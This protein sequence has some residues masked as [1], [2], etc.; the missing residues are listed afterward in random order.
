[1]AA[2]GA[3]LPSPPHTHRC[4]RRGV[5]GHGLTKRENG[6]VAGRYV[7][8]PGTMARDGSGVG[9]PGHAGE[10]RNLVADKVE[11]VTK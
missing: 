6:P 9:W 11:I 3:P 5:S 1:M 10:M 2:E 7:H 4:R 8:Y